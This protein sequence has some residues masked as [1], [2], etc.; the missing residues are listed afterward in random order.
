MSYEHPA[1]S[2]DARHSLSKT[3]G[4]ASGDWLQRLPGI[5]A[6]C[7]EQWNLKVDFSFP[8]LSYNYVACATAGDGAEVVLKVCPTDDFEFHTEVEALRLFS[9]KGAIKLLEWDVN[10]GAMLLERLKPGEQLQDITDDESAIGIACDTMEKL[11]TPA[12]ESRLFP[13][14]ADWASGLDRLR[15]RYD[16]GT[17]PLPA[18]LVDRCERLFAELHSSASDSVLLH[19]DLHPGNI[20]S[21]SRGWVAIDPK[22]LIGEREYEVGA[23]M[24]NPLPELLFFDNP[25]VFI[26]KRLDQFC[27]R[28]SFD[29]QRLRDWTFAQSVLSAWWH[30]EDSGHGWEPAI[31]FAE[32][33]LSI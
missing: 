2:A 24:R 29:R 33:V 19:G 25:Q 21:S 30:I 20:L 3:R 11:W 5:L 26:G 22:G 32:L 28:L 10:W 8:N 6:D 16:G 7:E 4:S 23:W 12:P 9:G 18:V 1:L 17:G 14:T 27:E 13:T 31:Q 15:R